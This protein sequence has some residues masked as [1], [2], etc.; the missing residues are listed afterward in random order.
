MRMQMKN[1]S[2]VFHPKYFQVGCGVFRCFEPMEWGEMCSKAAVCSL[3]RFLP[4][5]RWEDESIPGLFDPVVFA[6][7]ALKYLKSQDEKLT[8]VP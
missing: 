6:L 8:F 5:V 1:T 3:H 7:G 4:R 2:N